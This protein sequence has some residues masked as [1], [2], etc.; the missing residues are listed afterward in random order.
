MASIL[1]PSAFQIK[2]K[3]EHVVKGIKTTNETFFTLGNIT[4]VDRR[5]VTIPAQTPID[6]FNVNGVRPSAGTFPSSSM[7]YARITNLDTTSSLAVSF[8]SSKSPDGIGV[9]GTDLTSS[10]TSGGIGGVIGLYAAIP[11][12]ASVSGSGMTLDVVVSSSLV[13]S[14]SLGI[15]SAPTDCATGTYNVNLAGGSGVGATAQAIV[16]GAD[17]SIPTLASVMVLNPGRGYV[18]GDVLTI[19]DGGLGTGQLITAQAF[20]NNGLIPNVSNDIIREIAVYTTT[21]QGGTVNVRSVGG[22]V[23]TVTP[24]NIGT[25]YLQGQVITISQA[26]LINVGFGNVNS[27]YTCTLQPGDVAN[28]SAASMLALTGSNINTS[29][30]QAKI[31]AGGSGYETGETVT[32]NGAEIGNSTDAIFTLTLNDFTENGARSYWTMDVLPTSSLMFSSPQVTGSTFNGFFEQ[33]IEFVSVYAET[34]RMDVEYVVVN[35]DN[36]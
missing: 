2:I 27:D 35:S 10:Y 1:T 6:L 28:S 9:I 20:T 5:I 16:T 32:V 23:S 7:K 33:D 24:V 3:E 4:N 34:E 12:T 18:V 22:V 19:N 11:T 30:F 36:A 21:G 14:Q 15:N 26:Q 31:A 17:P 25:G 29:I 13:M 8:T